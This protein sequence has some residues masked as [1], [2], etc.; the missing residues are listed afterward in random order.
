MEES[1]FPLDNS[2]FESNTESIALEMTAKGSYKW[3]IK[4]RSQTLLEAD[5]QRLKDLDSKL[6][7]D[8]PNYCKQ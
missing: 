6:R 3:T 5:V 8:F 2:G 7:N 4:V 1:N